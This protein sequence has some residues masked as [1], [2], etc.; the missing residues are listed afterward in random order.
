MRR[1]RARESGT[2]QRCALYRLGV[3]AGA[4]LVAALL[5][6]C[7]PDVPPRPSPATSTATPTP[8]AISP[9]SLVLTLADL[10]EGYSAD[11]A[12]THAVNEI[13]GGDGYQAAFQ[14]TPEATGTQAVKSVAVVFASDA[15]ARAALTSGV[16]GLER[17]SQAQLQASP[18]DLGTGAK[19][20]SFVGSDGGDW[21]SVAWQD[22][23]VFLLLGVEYRAMV[24]D[25]G[26]LVAMARIMDRAARA[27]GAGGG[28][29]PGGSPHPGGTPSPEATPSADATPNGGGSPDP[30]GNPSPAGG[31][32]GCVTITD[33][34]A[35]AYAS[36]PDVS[37]DCLPRAADLGAAGQVIGPNISDPGRTFPVALNIPIAS[38]GTVCGGRYSGTIRLH[39][40][41][42][43]GPLQIVG[44][45]PGDPFSLA[46]GATT[47]V[48]VTIHVPDGNTY[49]GPLGLDIY[50]GD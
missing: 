26:P 28:P 12:N 25:T 33:I 1:R 43:G 48:T 42:S 20:Y 36:S 47:R 9:A 15:A 11:P 45:A 4:C 19:V 30:G 17:E 41:S 35:S 27:A 31:C 6:G 32:F 21:L 23:G 16:A 18:S 29:T 34:T 5:A 7:L 40:D 24:S 37:V 13:P 38:N 8:R 39:Y 2:P 10:G 46:A 14:G 22:G 44:I 50:V 49:N 3:M